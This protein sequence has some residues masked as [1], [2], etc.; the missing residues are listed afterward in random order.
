MR[1]A[2]IAE[3]VEAL[4]EKGKTEGGW[5]FLAPS[6]LLWSSVGIWSLIKYQ[7]DNE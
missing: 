1:E 7:D 3:F 6:W 2:E 5:L 4:K